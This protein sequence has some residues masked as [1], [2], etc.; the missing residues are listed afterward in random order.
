DAKMR[1]STRVGLQKLQRRLGATTVYVTQDQ[2]EAMLMGDRIAV[3][4]DGALQQLGTP[5][6]LYR[7]PA[8]MFVA[9][10]F[11][12]PAMNIVPAEVEGDEAGLFVKRGLLRVRVPTHYAERLSDR[13]GTQIML[14]LRPEAIH[15]ARFVREADPSTVVDAQVDALEAMG[16]DV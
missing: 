7:R 16:R 11:G 1:A 12:S 3:M 8:N 5:D 15:D 10:F 13:K 4:K 9:G 14:G 6:A 2:V